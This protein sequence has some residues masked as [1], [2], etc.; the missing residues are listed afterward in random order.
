MNLVMTHRNLCD[1]DRVVTLRNP[2]DHKLV[3]V[4]TMPQ[5]ED[6]IDFLF[7]SLFFSAFQQRPNLLHLV[8]PDF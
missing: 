5:T 8:S 7:S 1:H 2:C 6:M 3:I 4:M